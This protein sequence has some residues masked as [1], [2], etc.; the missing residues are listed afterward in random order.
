VAA[1]ESI[2]VPDQDHHED[3]EQGEQDEADAERE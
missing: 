3:I 1:H 2:F